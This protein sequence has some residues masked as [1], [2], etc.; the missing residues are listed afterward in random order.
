MTTLHNDQD[1][2]LNVHMPN[3]KAGADTSALGILEEPWDALTLFQR[4]IVRSRVAGTETSG[5]DLGDTKLH[6]T[7]LETKLQALSKVAY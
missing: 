7:A 6:V 2:I 1:L 4:W 3:R 5:L